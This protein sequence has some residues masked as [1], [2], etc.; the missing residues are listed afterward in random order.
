MT[1]LTFITQ[2][3]FEPEMLTGATPWTNYAILVALRLKTFNTRRFIGVLLYKIQEIHFALFCCLTHC[4]VNENQLIM[5]II[6]ELFCRFFLQIITF[7][8]WTLCG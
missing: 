8:Q 6:K 1:V 7:F 4:K 2:F 5:Q 3:V